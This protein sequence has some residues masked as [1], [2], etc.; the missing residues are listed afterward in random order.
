MNSI[1]PNYNIQKNVFTVLLSYVLLA[2]QHM[3]F[4]SN[5]VQKN[6]KKN[7]TLGLVNSCHPLNI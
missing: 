4:N 2:K 1:C 6:G 7:L 5:Y 3:V